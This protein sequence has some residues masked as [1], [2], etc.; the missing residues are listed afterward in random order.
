[1]RYEALKRKPVTEAHARKNMMIYLKNMAGFKMDF[2][3]GMT[4]TDIRPIFENH[5]NLNQAFLERVEEEV[6]GQKEEEG[7]NDDDDVYTEATPLAF[8]V[9]VV[10]YQIHHENNKPYY[11]IIKADGIHQ[12]FLSFI[13]LLKKF[14]RE[15]L[16]MLWKLVQERFQSLEPKNFSDDFLLNTLKT[17]FEK[18]NVEA[19]IWRD[20]RG[21]YGAAEVDEKTVARRIYTRV[22]IIEFGDSYKAYPEETGKGP[23]SESSAKKKGRTVV[24]TIENMQKRRNDVKAR[25][26]LLLA[27][28]DEHQLRFNTYETAKEIWEAILK[29]FGG[30]EATKKTKKNQLK[31][32]YGNFKDEEVFD[33]L[34][35]EWLMYIIV[36]RNRNDLDIMSL[37]DVYNHLKVYETEVQKKSESNSQNMAFISSSNTSSGKGFE[38]SKVECFNFHKMGHFA[39]ECRA[40]GSQDRGERE[41][42]KQGPEEEEPAPKALMA[43]DG[44]RWD[45]SYM[46]NE[47]ENH[48]LIADDE[49]PTEFALMSK[50]SSSLENEVEARLVE[51]KEHE[52]KFCEK[53]RG[54]DR[55]VEVEARLLEFKEHEIKFYEKIRGLERDVEKINGKYVEMYRNTSKSPKV[56]GNQQNW[57]NLKSQQLGKDFLMQNKACFKCGYFNHLASDC[58][59]W[60]EKRKTWPKNNFAHKRMTP[61]VGLLKPGTTPIAVSRPNMN[62]AQPKMTSFAK[63]AHSNV[64]RPFQGKSAVRTQPRVP[65]I[66]TVTKKIPTVDL[67]FPTAKS[68]FTADLGNKGKAVKASTC[69]IWRPKQNTT[70]KGLNCNGVSV[71]FKKYQYIDTQGRLKHQVIPKECHLYAV[72]RIFR[73][74]KGHPKLGLWYPK[75]SPFDLVAYSDNYYGGDTQDRKSTT[76][77]CQFLGRRLILWQCKKQTIVATS[78]TEA[79]YVAAAIGCGQVLL[80][81]NQMLDY[82]QYT[83]R[84][85]WIAQSK[86]LSPAA[87]EPASLLR[88][89]GQGEAFP[90][91]SSLDAR[92]DRENIAKTSALPYESSPRVTFLDANEGSMQYIIHELMK[93][94]TSLRSA[95]PTQEDAPI[96]REII[97][98]G[99]ELGADKS[100][101]LGSNDTKEM[102]NVLSLMEATNILTSGGAAAS[103]SPA[104]VLPAAGVPTVSGSFPTVRAIFTTASVRLSEQL[105]RDSKIARLHA[106]EELKMM[107]EGLD[108]SNEVIAKHLQEYEQAEGDLSVVEKLELI[109]ELV[110]YQDHSAKIL[111]YQAQQSKPLSKKEQREFYM[112]LVPLEEVYVEALQVKHPIIDWEIHSEGKREYWKIIRLGVLDE[113][114]IEASSPGEHLILETDWRC[115]IKFRGELLGIKC[116][117][118]FPLLVMVFPLLVHFAT[119]S[120][121]VSHY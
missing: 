80:T 30:N 25:T 41:S 15:A 94:C 119:V 68:T 20:Q 35:P 37:D 114:L 46:A 98:I 104:E 22:K 70:K 107:I 96:T 59:V 17:M 6:I 23:A 64:K 105:V 9:P 36:W 52:I 51:F 95:E 69:W 21:R 103:V 19:S 106:E 74:L 12:L 71:T 39:R 48:A 2:F 89:D 58:G 60:V 73:Y 62:V 1:M 29:T 3:K 54:I 113:E 100:T 18:P 55:D 47:E 65:R 45:W 117:K 50:S 101:E 33:N 112:A 121:K 43:I 75:E 66:S 85:K 34:A 86:A 84:A 56:W 67:K 109:N 63:T 40:P 77:G 44:I 115:N 76:G 4:Y 110:K 14:D 90:T 24:I 120:A 16:E 5:Y 102:V 116:F 108:R 13:T 111:K 79:E 53:I 32:Q 28:P 82:G 88:D 11:K 10:D 78:T 92:Q 7:T 87:D 83:R 99:E 42:Y 38:K 118:A 57:N 26:T 91:L 49:V 8:K 97:E 81:Q 72:I 93:L 31:Q 27:L 61:K